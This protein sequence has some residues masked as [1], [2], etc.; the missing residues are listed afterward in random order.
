MPLNKLKEC[1]VLIVDD[2]FSDRL[3]LLTFLKYYKVRRIQ[4]A[5]DGGIALFKIDNA[6]SI[7]KPFHLIFLDLNMPRANGLQLLKKIKEEKEH[8]NIYVILISNLINEE[9][10]ENAIDRGVD[11]ILVKPYTRQQLE[12]KMV[13][14]MLTLGFVSKEFKIE[15]HASI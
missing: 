7:R 15:E 6:F 12:E 10:V 4:E 13:K 11:D 14:A 9:K 8:S 3:K 5:E 2:N 1:N